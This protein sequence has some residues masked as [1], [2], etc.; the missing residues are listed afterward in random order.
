MIYIPHT[1]YFPGDVVFFKV[2]YSSKEFEERLELLKSSMVG[3]NMKM[4]LKFELG[5]I[6]GV[7]VEREEYDSYSISIKL[8]NGI[9]A[10]CNLLI[11]EF[12]LIMRKIV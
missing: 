6:K 9:I 1:E 11:G 12:N 2:K 7:V 10:S 5:L 8:P 3:F 4:I